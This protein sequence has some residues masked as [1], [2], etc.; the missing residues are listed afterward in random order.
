MAGFFPFL[1]VQII[2]G[3]QKSLKLKIIMSKSNFNWLNFMVV[4]NYSSGRMIEI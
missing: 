3:S 4:S 1:E 2:R